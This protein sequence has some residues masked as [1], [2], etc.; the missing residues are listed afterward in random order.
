VHR[1]Q[2]TAV[3]YTYTSESIQAAFDPWLTQRSP[4]DDGEMRMFCPVCEVPGVSRTPSA[5]INPAKGKWN[6]LGKCGE[7]GS[8]AALAQEKSVEIRGT[9]TRTS[10][11]PKK[12][13][14]PPPLDDQDKRLYWHDKFMHGECADFFD[15]LTQERGLNVETLEFFKIGA[16]GER[17]TIPIMHRGQCINVR[18]YLPHA[19]SSARKMLNL[20]GHGS[21]AMLAFTETL[22]GNSLPVVVAE[23]ELDAALLWQEAQGRLAVVTGTGGSGKPPADVSALRGRE[24]WVAYDNDD[25]GRHG[26]EKF[27][28]HAKAAGALARI[29]DLTRLGLTGNGADVSDY[30]LRG[31]TVDALLTEMARLRS[32]PGGDDGLVGE[33]AELMV[34]SDETQ[35]LDFMGDMLTDEQIGELDP[36]AWTVQGWALIDNYTSIYGEPGVMKTFAILDLLR[37]VRAGVPWLGNLTQRG[38]ALLFEGEGLTQLQPRIAAWNAYQQL[39]AA[40][41]APGLS[42]AV[43]VDLST[44]EGVARVVRTVRAAESLWGEPVLMVAFDPAVEFMPNEDVET[45]DLFTRGVRA[46]ARYLHIAV[47]VGHHSN[48]AG[49]RARGGDQMRMRAGVHVRME[50]IDQE[51]GV[52]GVVQEKNRFAAPLA[53][54]VAPLPQGDSLVLTL[55]GRM[56]RA[57]YAAARENADRTANAVRQ[58]ARVREF[59]VANQAD[60]EKTVME[61]LAGNPWLSGRKVRAAAHGIGTETV[62][63]VLAALTTRG[64]L[65]TR[66]APRNST[67]Y[68]LAS[69]VNA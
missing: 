42:G 19:P 53:M 13:E 27:A 22:T 60:A 12:P 54:E 47:I 63:T 44:P 15:F 64:A 18:R 36:P 35:I 66:P 65:V 3:N 7:G 62:Q 5:S 38:A 29:L 37:S 23:G 10:T 14:F 17:I 9:R 69:E 68:A 43:S 58:R 30:L 31:G 55:E 2:A 48:A 46:L 40:D 59:V 67:E 34:Q 1:Q 24:V 61:V 32:E 33:I 16:D 50:R 26:A 41:L 56:S 51:R 4:S 11:Q 6:C 39:A 8:I 28:A 21:P 57:E 45:M 25:A 20:P 52:V 49:E